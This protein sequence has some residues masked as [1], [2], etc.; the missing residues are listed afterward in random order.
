MNGTRA[1]FVE[2]SDGYKPD[3]EIVEHIEPFSMA[4][5][6]AQQNLSLEKYIEPYE[7]MLE[8]TKAQAERERERQEESK[9]LSGRLTAR[10]LA[11]RSWM[12]A[13]KK[14]SSNEAST[15]KKKTKAAGLPLRKQKGT[16]RK[17]A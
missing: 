15:S 6:I 11:G 8:K 9:S 17:K 4:C 1:A 13:G 2:P 5:L 10:D 7:A 16:G 14:V 3:P 12:S